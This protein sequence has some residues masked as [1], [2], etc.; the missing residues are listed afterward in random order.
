M[1]KKC[2]LLT[3]GSR[4]IGAAIVARLAKD[5]YKVY[6]NYRRSTEAAE[7][8]AEDLCSKGHEIC[9]LQGDVSNSGDVAAMF[10]AIE[11][12]G[13]TIHLLVNNAGVALQ[14]LVQDTDEVQ[15]DNVF[16]VNAKGTFLMCKG[17][18]P[19]MIRKQEG[20]IINIS[21]VWGETGGSYE[22][23]YSASKAAVIG[24]TKAMAKEV[25]PSGIRVN[26][27]TPGVIA[28][29]MTACYSPEVMQELAE[30]TPLMRNGTP[31]DVA[32]AVSF[33]ASEQAG[34]VTGQ[35]FG[36]NGGMLI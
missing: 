11:Q 32:N 14:G 35:V 28:T 29:D 9:L 30:E 33:L 8:L 24:L 25:G 27:I 12:A 36:V 4:G 19:Q 26:C 23:V 3:G 20:V 6:V 34:F 2:A 10:Q 15:W 1:S 5:G 31:E 13:D 21:S 16:G 17:V 22:A 18:L 7:A